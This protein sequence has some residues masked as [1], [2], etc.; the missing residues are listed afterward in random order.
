M[1]CGLGGHIE[2]ESWGGQ[3]YEQRHYN[4]Y[5]LRERLVQPA[6]IHF[7]RAVAIGE[8]DGGVG[9]WYLSLPEEEQKRFT[10]ENV[11]RASTY[12][13]EYYRVEDENQFVVHRSRLS[14]Q[15]MEDASVTAVLMEKRNEPLPQSYFP[16]DPL[17]SYLE[18]QR[19]CKTKENGSVGL[20]IEKVELCRAHGGLDPSIHFQSAEAID[21]F[22]TFACDGEVQ[23]PTFR[24]LF[25]D[26]Y[27]NVIVGLTT[28]QTGFMLGTCRGRNRLR[29]RFDQLNLLPGEYWV[30]VGAWEYEQPDPVP[31]FPYDVKFKSN[32]MEI[33]PLLPGLTGTAFMPYNLAIEKLPE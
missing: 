6:H 32:R 17:R 25:Q 24:V 11:H 22:I 1:P 20:K 7:V 2:S 13:R 3:E 18:N 16:Y 31:P 26:R 21:V 30:T 15:D 28:S 9:R 14:Q 12:W 33:G 29:V 8:V 4:E 19:L 10:F 27:D 23:E 5:T